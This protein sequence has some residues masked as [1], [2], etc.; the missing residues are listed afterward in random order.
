MKT[1]FILEMG[2]GDKE[3]GHLGEIKIIGTKPESTPYVAIYAR[4]K[5]ASPTITMWL[6]DADTERFAVNILKAL[7]SKHLKV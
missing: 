4:G 1:E 3:A 6:K 2:N 5:D 7:K